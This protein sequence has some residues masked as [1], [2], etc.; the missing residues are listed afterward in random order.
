MAAGKGFPQE[1]FRDVFKLSPQPTIL[2]SLT[3]GKPEPNGEATAL[4]GYGRDDLA[5]IPLN[6]L[7]A[8]S[9]YRAALR[10]LLVL[11]RKQKVSGQIEVVKKNGRVSPV[12]FSVALLGSSRCVAVLHD[13][14]AE[15]RKEEETRREIAQLR[16]LAE[17]S[18]I[19]HALFAG[20]KLVHANGAF[21]NA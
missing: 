21:R 9:S 6:R 10:A 4:L 8:P 18:P 16:P 7:I 5:R 12:K 14:S 3:G 17:G 2:F 15:R 13:L 11:R 20:R 19:P 1:F